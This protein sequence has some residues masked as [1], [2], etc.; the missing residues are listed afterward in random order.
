MYTNPISNK[1]AETD[2]E[3]TLERH[4][5]WIVDQ[6]NDTFFFSKAHGNFFIHHTNTLV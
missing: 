4:F 5:D 6:K 3:K 2:K 1:A